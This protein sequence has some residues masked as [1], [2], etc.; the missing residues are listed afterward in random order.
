MD[1]RSFLVFDWPL[2][3][4]CRGQQSIG[5][6][7]CSTVQTLGIDGELSSPQDCGIGRIEG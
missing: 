3:F 1:S 7:D 2:L 4:A 5:E 6:T